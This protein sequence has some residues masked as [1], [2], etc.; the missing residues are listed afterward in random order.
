[1]A[2]N[3]VKSGRV[4]IEVKVLN[5]DRI[6]NILW[7][8]HIEIYKVKKKNISTIS[9]GKIRHE[10]SMIAESAITLICNDMKYQDKE[11][12]PEYLM[13]NAKY[14]KNQDDGSAS[15]VGEI[16]QIIAKKVM[17]IRVR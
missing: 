14:Q 3:N 4:T 7:N 10:P 8:K 17:V 15:L 11:S 5:P 6:L 9:D 13:L 16:A 1:M 12:D 2:L